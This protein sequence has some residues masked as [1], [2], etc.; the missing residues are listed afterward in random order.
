MIDQPSLVFNRV[1]A[2]DRQEDLFPLDLRKSGAGRGAVWRL[3]QID[4]NS[5]RL[6][7][8]ALFW[9]LFLL[10]GG[11]FFVAGQD[12]I[13]CLQNFSCLKDQAEYF[14][15]FDSSLERLPQKL[16]CAFRQIQNSSVNRGDQGEPSKFRRR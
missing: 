3:I 2:P 14:S 5:M 8:D 13:G 16:P 11:F 12:G 6:N 15:P 10:Q 9:K 1:N 7:D 4:R